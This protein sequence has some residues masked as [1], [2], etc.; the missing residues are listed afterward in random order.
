[1]PI[2]AFRRGWVSGQRPEQAGVQGECLFPLIGFGTKSQGLNSLGIF[3]TF[4][5][6]TVQVSFFLFFHS[7]VNTTWFILLILARKEYFLSFI[8]FPQSLL[9]LNYIFSEML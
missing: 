8:L 9:M 3:F 4:Q 5:G 2:S 1:M 6:T 7:L